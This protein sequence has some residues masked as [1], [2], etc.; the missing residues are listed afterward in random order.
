V[1]RVGTHVSDS[2]APTI[3]FSTDGGA[4]W[5]DGT[6]PQALGG[7]GGAPLADG[8]NGGTVAA[9]ADG[10]RFVWAP[11]NGA[12]HATEGFGQSWTASQGIPQGARVE[13][14]R[15]DPEVFYGLHEGTFYVSTDGGATFAAS[16]ATA[17]PA[18]ASYVAAT[19]SARG[20]VW[21]AGGTSP[22][23]STS[24]PTAAA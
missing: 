3:Q 18:G 20:E 9:A 7:L 11:S 6:L 1:V 15:V 19:T 17:P 22:A 12:V 5:F 21:V 16:P 13:A 14:D 2:T 23:T 10:S 24:A 4:N 8:V